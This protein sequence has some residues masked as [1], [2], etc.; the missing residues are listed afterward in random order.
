MSQHEQDAPERDE[1]VVVN[2]SRRGF[3]KGIAATGALVVAASWGMPEAFAASKRNAFGA[4]AMPHGWVD[5]PRCSSASPPMV[6]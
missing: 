6:W 1:L 3:L 5:N 4:D 2:L